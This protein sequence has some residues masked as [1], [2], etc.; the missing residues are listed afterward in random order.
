MIDFGAFEKISGHPESSR[1][2]NIND[3]KNKRNFE[4]KENIDLGNESLLSLEED[5]NT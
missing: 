1:Y 5:I 3:R 4:N 2:L